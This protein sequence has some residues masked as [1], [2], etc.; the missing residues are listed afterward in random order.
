MGRFAPGDFPDYALK[1]QLFEESWKDSGVV[2]LSNLHV[3]EGG[4]PLFLLSCA[5]FLTPWDLT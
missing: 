1:M 4:G 3:A 2:M 5:R